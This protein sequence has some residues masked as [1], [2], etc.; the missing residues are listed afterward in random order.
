MTDIASDILDAL[1]QDDETVRFDP[2]KLSAV[3]RRFVAALPAGDAVALTKEVLGVAFFLDVKKKLREPA[4][5]VVALART[6]AA[7]LQRLGHKFG[8][9]ADQQQRQ[10]EKRLGQTSSVIPVGE[11]GGSGAKWWD[12]R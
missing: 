11:R 6:A 1:V 10:A 9:L 7:T 12:L 5:Q 3:Q 8:D 2:D 4:M